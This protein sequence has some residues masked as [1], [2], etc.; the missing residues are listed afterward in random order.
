MG[1]EP[2]ASGC[3]GKLQEQATSLLSCTL[4]VWRKLGK[5]DFGN[6]R[7]SLPNT[8]FKVLP[9]SSPICSMFSSPGPLRSGSVFPNPK[10]SSIPSHTGRQ[11]RIKKKAQ[12]EKGEGG[13]RGVREE[14]RD[15][16]CLPRVLR[17]QL[18][19]PPC[20]TPREHLRHGEA[21]LGPLR[22]ARDIPWC[23][24]FECPAQKGMSQA[25]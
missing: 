18:G 13:R 17:P 24:A 1:Q 6:S 19:R 16:P 8:F 5:E 11:R 22:R 9:S 3:S 4:H 10:V 15:L 23:S 12:K 21:A 2:R 20:P 14:K 25:V 7:C